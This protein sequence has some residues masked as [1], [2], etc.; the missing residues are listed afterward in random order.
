MIF[1]DF[2]FSIHSRPPPRSNQ[3]SCPCLHS[4]Q[5][6]VMLRS[7]STWGTSSSTTILRHQEFAWLNSQWA[8]SDRRVCQLLLSSL[9]NQ[10]TLA[11][12]RWG[13]QVTVSNAEADS[14]GALRWLSGL[15]SR[16]LSL[17]S[18]L[19]LHLLSLLLLL[20]RGNLVQSLP[21]FHVDCSVQWWVGL[22]F[23]R[24]L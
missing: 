4:S 3:T 14:H 6:S 23:V 12:L 11:H 20:L 13:T 2:S 7:V 16:G 15:K 9:G 19:W 24:H 1:Y 17:W 10:T 21:L 22:L 18:K 8:L 5:R